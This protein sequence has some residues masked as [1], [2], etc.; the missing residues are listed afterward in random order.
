MC[1]ELGLSH[2]IKRFVLVSV[3][4][5]VQSIL[6][7]LFSSRKLDLGNILG[8][9]DLSKKKSDQFFDLGNAFW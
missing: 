4:L 8:K 6:W 5:S 3:V 2:G 1:M 7:L 9:V